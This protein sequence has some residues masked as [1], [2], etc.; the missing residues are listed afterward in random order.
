MPDDNH[1][2]VY[3]FFTNG[4][5]EKV[6]DHVGVPDAMTA[7]RHYTDNV[8]VRMGI[9]TRVIIVDDTDDCICFEW[10]KGEGVVF[11]PRE[12]VQ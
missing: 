1:F 9:V 4:T 10:I 8:A 5:Y 12:T 7:V 3:Q 2:S 6:R 11:P